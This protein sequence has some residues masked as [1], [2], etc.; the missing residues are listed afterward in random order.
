MKLT[1]QEYVKRTLTPSERENWRTVKRQKNE[2]RRL[3][4][5]V[6]LYGDGLPVLENGI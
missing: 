5:R 6:S 1:E 3:C 2:Y 4:E